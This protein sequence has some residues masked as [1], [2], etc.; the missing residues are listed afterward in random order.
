[1]RPQKSDSK[2]PLIKLLAESGSMIN[3]KSNKLRNSGIEEAVLYAC[4]DDQEVTQLSA[5][6]NKLNAYW[7]EQHK[8][9][10]QRRAMEA[11]QD[12]NQ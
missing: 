4:L 3:V 2:D 7:K 9:H 6:L 8:A 12:N 5:M 10:H 11:K 1:M